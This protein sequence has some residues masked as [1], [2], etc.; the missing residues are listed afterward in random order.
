M[1]LRILTFKYDNYYKSLCCLNPTKLNQKQVKIKFK[2]E[3]Y[4]PCN[5]PV[6]HTAEIIL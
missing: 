6:L 3:W 2:F 4:H 1:T 5:C